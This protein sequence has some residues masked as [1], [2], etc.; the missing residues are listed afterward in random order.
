MPTPID[1]WIIGSQFERL[2]A[3]MN[4][5]RI[6]L[7]KKGEQEPLAIFQEMEDGLFGPLSKLRRLLK[8][9]FPEIPKQRTPEEVETG[10]ANK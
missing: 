7:L 3:A 6:E 9:P 5:L 10:A 1:T 8:V 2:H 4:T